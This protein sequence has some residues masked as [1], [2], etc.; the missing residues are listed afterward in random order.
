MDRRLH[1][2][3]ITIH[4]ISSTP[5]FY[6]CDH[7]SRLIF[8]LQIKVSS[9]N[10]SREKEIYVRGPTLSFYNL[11]TFFIIGPIFKSLKT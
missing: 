10:H 1:A 2:S 6:Q 5:S 4:T 9:T 3:H 11:L 7:R 8:I